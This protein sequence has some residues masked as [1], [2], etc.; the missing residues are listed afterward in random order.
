MFELLQVTANRLERT[1]LTPNQLREWLDNARED[2]RLE[3]L[4]AI[5]SGAYR[6]QPVG[7]AEGELTPYEEAMAGVA[8]PAGAVVG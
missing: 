1:P 8:A 4:Q 6:L 3:V 2:E 7:L 5:S